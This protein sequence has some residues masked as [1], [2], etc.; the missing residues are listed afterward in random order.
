MPPGSSLHEQVMDPQERTLRWLL[1]YPPTEGDREEGGEGDREKEERGREREAGEGQN[2]TEERGTEKKGERY[3]SSAYNSG[4]EP[5]CV[6]TGCLYHKT[7]K[8][9]PSVA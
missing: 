4:G 7:L 9:S 5:V 6:T 3:C 1:S 8:G 2:G